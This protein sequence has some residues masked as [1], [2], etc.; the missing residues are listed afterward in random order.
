ML[1]CKRFN[2]SKPE[3]KMKGWTANWWIP[4]FGDVNTHTMT[5]LPTKVRNEIPK[6]QKE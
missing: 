3:I 4:T 2:L 5:T 6:N 1:L